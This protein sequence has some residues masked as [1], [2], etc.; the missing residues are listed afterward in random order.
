MGRTNRSNLSWN[1]PDDDPES[2]RVSEFIG[3]RKLDVALNCGVF[4]CF[5]D[6]A[7]RFSYCGG[8]LIARV[9]ALNGCAGDACR[10][11]AVWACTWRAVLFLRARTADEGDASMS[12]ASI[13]SSSSM[14]PVSLGPRLGDEAGE[15]SFH[16]S[17]GDEG[18]DDAGG[19]ERS[20]GAPSIGSMSLG[21][22]EGGGQ[23]ERR[24]SVK[25]GTGARPEPESG[26]IAFWFRVHWH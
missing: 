24:A 19:P 9:D 23:R 16:A 2:C 20:M 21:G 4:F 14:S 10:S 17:I 5:G 6:P 8:C 12:S 7:G 15:E 22:D 25:G 3:L 18:G 11:C 13:S 1:D 26:G